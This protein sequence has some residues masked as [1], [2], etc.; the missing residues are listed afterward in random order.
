MEEL[1]EEI[2]TTFG[3]KGVLDV[4]VGPHYKIDCIFDSAVRFGSQ[5]QIDRPYD[6]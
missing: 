4:H 6:T 1:Q 3:I 5:C 2:F